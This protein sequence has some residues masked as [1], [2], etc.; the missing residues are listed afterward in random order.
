MCD[1]E[2]KSTCGLYRA[3]PSAPGGSIKQFQ[4]LGSFS[5]FITQD[6]PDVLP[7]LVSVS[8]VWRITSLSFSSEGATVDSLF[9]LWT[10]LG[11]VRLQGKA[12]TALLDK[13]DVDQ[14]KFPTST[15]PYPLLS[16][17]SLHPRETFNNPTWTCNFLSSGIGPHSGVIYCQPCAGQKATL[18]SSLAPEL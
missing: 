3:S 6:S 10:G 4:P 18:A 8:S 7:V 17:N 11:E 16:K 2:G 13:D 5:A 15:S 14:Q 1:T 9:A 12:G